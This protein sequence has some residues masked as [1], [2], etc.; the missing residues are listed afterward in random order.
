[1]LALGI[2]GFAFNTSHDACHGAYSDNRAVNQMMAWTFDVLGSSSYVWTW[3]HNFLHHNFTSVAGL[4]DDIDV[5]LFGSLCPDKPLSRVHRFQH[6]YLWCLYAL[7]R[8]YINRSPAGLQLRLLRHANCAPG[9]H[10]WSGQPSMIQ[11]D[12][13]QALRRGLVPDGFVPHDGSHIKRVQGLRWNTK[14]EDEGSVL[15]IGDWNMQGERGIMMR[16]RRTSDMLTALGLIGKAIEFLV[17]NISKKKIYLVLDDKKR[18]AKAFIRLHE[19]ILGL[20]VISANFMLY[21][22]GL[23]GGRNSRMYMVHIRR[24]SEPL[25]PA[26]LEFVEALR[27]VGPVLTFYD[28][29]LQQ[30]LGQVT[31]GKMGS[32]KNFFYLVLSQ[33]VHYLT[34][35]APGPGSDPCRRPITSNQIKRDRLRRRRCP[36]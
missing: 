27:E 30:A 23:K 10:T 26:S 33:P 6:L 3:K 25:K 20:E 13:K 4:D 17:T 18:A 21:I 22:E 11:C 9:V 24:I 14:G 5:G 12:G 28:P 35:S 2:A 8:A 29:A 19:A 36:H 31:V 32:M 15:I 7:L 1:M 16:P 34:N